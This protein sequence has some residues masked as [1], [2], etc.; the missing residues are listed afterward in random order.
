MACL[1]HPFENPLQPPPPLFVVRHGASPWCCVSMVPWAERGYE[2]GTYGRQEMDQVS[3]GT[4]GGSANQ[5]TVGR[6]RQGYGVK[7]PSLRVLLLQ[8]PR[9]L[10]SINGH[11]G[12]GPLK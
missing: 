4:A 1:A 6:S 9:S 12:P 3:G 8:W 5:A 7:S 10:M 11:Q 2:V